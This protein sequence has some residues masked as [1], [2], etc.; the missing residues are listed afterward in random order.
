MKGVFTGEETG[1]TE[2]KDP[3]GD[4]TCCRER[5]S[6]SGLLSCA[7]PIKFSYGFL[8]KILPFLFLGIADAYQ[9]FG[10]SLFVDIY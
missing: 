1:E 8:K 3:F 10:C 2:K 5:H 9:P 7:R 6:L 4:K